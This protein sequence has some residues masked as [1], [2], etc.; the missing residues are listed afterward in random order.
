MKM[1][2]VTNKALYTSISDPIK[3]IVGL[4]GMGRK[5]QSQHKLPLHVSIPLSPTADVEGDKG[6]HTL[7]GRVQSVKEFTEG[8]GE[9]LRQKTEELKSLKALVYRV[10]SAYQGTSPTLCTLG[11]PHCLETLHQEM[12]ALE[13]QAFPRKTVEGM[14]PFEKEFK[15][16]ENLAKDSQC[17]KEK[18]EKILEQISRATLLK[19]EALLD[20]QKKIE[21]AS[22]TLS[23]L[24]NRE[25]YVKEMQER[26]A[27]R[28][29]AHTAFNQQQSL[30]I[31][32]SSSPEF[33]LNNLK[34]HRE[35]TEEF[36]KQHDTILESYLPCHTLL[37]K[38]R[39]EFERHSSIA[40]LKQAGS[41]LL[42]ELAAKQADLNVH[43]E[44]LKSTGDHPEEETLKYQRTR[45]EYYEKH[46]KLV[47]DDMGAMEKK[48]CEILEAPKTFIEDSLK[49]I[50]FIGNLY[51]K[52]RDTQLNESLKSSY[53]LIQREKMEEAQNL[54]ALIT[55]LARA[56]DSIKIDMQRIDA[57]LKSKGT[58]G[59]RWSTSLWNLV[60]SPT[61]EDKE[62]TD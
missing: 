33:I 5:R 15:E 62:S 59:Y 1:S 58:L 57:S 45:K 49:N 47:A 11:D 41:L 53:V 22:L 2:S 42:Q 21:E 56:N 60:S 27:K 23:S 17:L 35:A 18:I 32:S 3:P 38:T 46:Y 20:V 30:A 26:I 12:A 31:L 29:G 48:I 55:S 40:L 50:F 44:R 10:V 9:V 54:R 39:W 14:H 16:G 4:K 52:D 6:E 51:F 43:K 19:E 28:E 7:S 34:A 61:L 37:E 13:K 25:I 8:Q 36:K 24:K